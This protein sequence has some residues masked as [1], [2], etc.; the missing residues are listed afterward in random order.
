MPR[1]LY[2]DV[3]T[4]PYQA[5]VWSKWVD[6]PVIAIERDWSLL[7]IAWQ[8]EGEKKIHV[9]S[10]KGLD[11][12]DDTPLLNTLHALLDEADWVVAH[13]GNKFDIPKVQARFLLEDYPPPAPFDTVDTLQ[14]LRRHF[15]GGLRSNRLDEVCQQLN[16]GG[17]VQHTGFAL[18]QG[19]MLG[20]DKSWATMEKYNKQD[21]VLLRE[22][23]LKIRP[24]MSSHPIMHVEGC[25]NCGSGHLRVVKYRRRQSF[26]YPQY[27]CQKC[28]SYFQGTRSIQDIPKP[29][30]K[31]G[32]RR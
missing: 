14:V 9:Q 6:G 5:H 31:S 11:P 23:Y 16:I 25:P 10:L 19:C 24:W 22:L 29:V 17:K 32:V 3:E 26:T 4:A 21:I 8:W 2:F 12:F 1:V 28:N 27:Q 7:C 15:K 13:N 20:E 30:F 18:W